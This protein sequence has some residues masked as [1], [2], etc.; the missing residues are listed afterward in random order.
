MIKLTQVH[1]ITEANRTEAI[2]ATRT[3]EVDEDTAQEMV[4][5]PMATEETTITMAHLITEIIT[6]IE[7][8]I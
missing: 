3:S 5:Y 6:T 2:E 4:D 8:K 7:R 1:G